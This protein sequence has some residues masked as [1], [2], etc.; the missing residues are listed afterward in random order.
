MSELVLHPHPLT[1]AGRTVTRLGSFAPGETLAC[2][3]ARAG[4]TADAPGWVVSIGGLEVP[5]ILWART[6]PRHGMTIEC[7]RLAGRDVLRVVAFIALA[8]ITIQTGGVAAYFGVTN[9]F[10]AF[11]INAGVYMAGTMIINKVL[12]PTRMEN[13]QFTNAAASA[14]YAVGGGRNRARPFEPLGLLFGTVRVVP[15]YAA[16][17]YAWFE[18]D[19]QYQYVQ[20]H[21]GLNCGSADQ[22]KIGAT[23]I[24]TYDGVE[25]ERA[26][27]PGGTTSLSAWSSVDTIAGAL[28]Q[29][30]GGVGTTVLRTSS[31]GAV[32][33][34]VDL[35]ASLYTMDD[36]GKLQAASL[37]V[38]A[39]RRL[40]P[41]GAWEA[42]DGS[43]S[44]TVTLSSSTTKP[45]RRTLDSGTVPTGQYEVRL[46]KVTADATATNAAN[47]VEWTSLKS[48][49][50]DAA[51]YSGQPRV[52]IR[53]KASGQLNG[54][55]D[56][57]SWIATSKPAPVWD[58]TNWVTQTTR[59]PGA[60]MLLFMRGIYD[61]TGRLMAGMGLA[62]SQID[63]EALQGFMLQCAAK[64]YTFDHWF[65]QAVSCM[66][67]LEAMAACGLGSFSLHT[68]K[69][70]VVWAADD[71]PIGG[72]VNMANMKAKSFRV[73]YATRELS[74]ELETTWLDRDAAWA[75]AS[76]RVLAP[77]VTVPRATA[78]YAPVGV[79]TQ[80]G[81][82]LAARRTMAQN[83]YQRKT[84][85]WEMDLEHLTF[86][87]FAVMALSH[88]LTQ[89]GYGGRLDAATNTAGVVTLT[90]SD[91]VPAGTSTRKIGLRIPGENGYRIFT[92]QGF[93][94]GDSAVVTLVE[95]WPAGVAF[96]GDSA[97]NPAWDTLWIYDFLTQPGKRLRVVSIEPT[98]NMGGA[99]IT[100][101]PEPDEFWTY[102]NSG[103][104]VAPSPGGG[105]AAL[106]V[107]NLRVTQ[108]RLALNY[109]P[110]TDLDLTWD[111]VGPY[112]HAQVWGAEAGNALA[113]LGLTRTSRYIGW[114]VDA[115][116]SYSL[117]VRAFDSLGRPADAVA[118]SYTV[119]L[120]NLPP[121]APTGLGYVTEPFGVRLYCAQN[122]EPDVV[123]YEW[124][125]GPVA[126]GATVLDA[127]GGTAFAW[128]VQ[129][130]GNYT[131]WVRGIDSAGLPGAWTSLPVTVAVPVATA[132][133]A[134]LVGA[135][136]QLDM[137][138]TAGAFA[139]AGF[140]LAY[141]DVYSTAVAVGTVQ[142]SRL[143]RRVDWGGSRR[144]WVTPIDVRGNLGTAA[145]VDVV[146]SAPG[147]VTATR[148]EVIDNNALLYWAPPAGGSLPIDRY[149]VRK[150]ASW[151]AGTLVGSNGNSTF[152][153]VFE[154]QAGLV[155]YWVAAVDSAGNVG[156]PV[157]IA[158]T[159]NAPPDYKLAANWQS[160]LTGTLT[161]LYAEAGALLGPVDVTETFGS[162][163]STR[164]W[165][166]P[167]DQISAGF[168]I[169]AEPSVV[170]G[171]Y[172][173][174]FD[175]GAVL[176]ATTV[177]ATL[178]YTVAA[179]TVAVSC[180]IY[181]RLLATDAWT[182]ATAGA[183]SVLATNF[184]YVRVVWSLS[185]TAGANLLRID[186][187]TL[188][189]SAKQRIDS[190]SGVVTNAAIGVWVPFAVAF[191]SADV[192]V[193]QPAGTAPLIP[194]VDYAGGAYPT[195]ATVR[196]YNLA[197][198]AVTGAFSWS[199]RGF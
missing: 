183:T 181:T 45:V 144:W 90:L 164:G 69:H 129:V 55:L 165:T 88:D 148:A 67:A 104:Y 96:P 93:T 17:P 64:G 120:V 95:A 127:R 169:Y 12:P 139:L 157:G 182:A 180:Q 76:L 137:G 186:S 116:K 9:P 138:A 75:S 197:G 20:L 178:G 54:A 151:V 108:Q 38:T 184:R 155:T 66:D 198:T 114:H 172:D 199:T 10:A 142:A 125:V 92:V 111:A 28:L 2:V 145:A 115:G 33:L 3:L 84:V 191:I 42:F 194:V 52:G 174:S 132:P 1:D 141:G 60:H 46:T 100:A 62:D 173:E 29:C 36:Q 166:S 97:S 73:D 43:G 56:E 30:P 53:I 175:Y 35:S 124:R 147:V 188:K 80:A 160:L 117:E 190:G 70:G 171:S 25:I 87:R 37:T 176:P 134:T 107:S 15:D 89:W 177:Q 122:P 133:V 128:A 103:A 158:A 86:R 193:V 16:Q 195:G 83:I 18:S 72:V 159:I 85:S 6:R 59:N 154:Q 189:L 27:F 110:S 161:N 61:D 40:L 57:V 101:V 163:F 170:S 135:E 162:H 50:V 26:G 79:T 118:A 113:Y 8:Y 11:A 168:P 81:G 143:R 153:T 22:I 121:A 146:V 150:G 4:V 156:T 131:V 196:L 39:Q 185:C 187:F 65:D 112:D 106:V 98:P 34:T 47:T 58:G 99:R 119:A 49:Q 7:R 21:A 77:G 149:E 19:D 63:L 68:G 192:P 51:N 126:D 130:A 13:P 5:A 109:D 78:R 74:D 94:G 152:A 32:R 102:V 14:T 31:A 167:Q 44:A 140:A 24:E 105:M 48:Y 123:A 23:A 82:L 136:L 91:P 41:A 179:G 71:Q